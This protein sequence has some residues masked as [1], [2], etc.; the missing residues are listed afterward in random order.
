VF[1]WYDD[2]PPAG[3]QWEQSW[4][5]AFKNGRSNDFVVGLVAA[6]HGAHYYIVDRVKGQWDFTETCRQLV[7]LKQRYRQTQR[8]YVEDAANGPAI[9]NVLRGQVPG[10]V[11]VTPQGSKEARAQAAQP[12]V[13]AGNVWLP[14]PRPHGRR[15]PGREWVDDFLHQ[16]CCFPNGAHDDDVDAFTQLIAQWAIPQVIPRIRLCELLSARSRRVTTPLVTG[17]L[18]RGSEVRALPGAHHASPTSS[19][20][21]SSRT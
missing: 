6:R 11:P 10:I 4:D 5:V 18:S 17:L 2:A 14:N 1:Q 7:A 21:P 9:V 15:I 3:A 20:S 19:P 8:I 16:L 13:E 12:F